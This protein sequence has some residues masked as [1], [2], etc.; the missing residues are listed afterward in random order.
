MLPFFGLGDGGRDP[1]PLRLALPCLALPACWCG[2]V[3]HF[4]L[5]L[6][7]LE[8]SLQSFLK[9]L[10]HGWSVPLVVVAQRRLMTGSALAR[11]WSWMSQQ[12]RYPFQ[13]FVWEL[14]WSNCSHQSLHQWMPAQS[15][16]LWSKIS[17]IAAKWFVMMGP[18]RL[19]QIFLLNWRWPPTHRKKI[20]ALSRSVVQS[21]QIRCAG[22]KGMLL[23]SKHLQGTRKVEVPRSMLKFG[24]SF[25]GEHLHV[26]NFSRIRPTFLGSH[27]ALLLEAC[28]CD[29]SILIQEHV[30]YLKK[31]G[32]YNVSREDAFDQLRFAQRAADDADGEKEA[33][34]TGGMRYLGTFL[35][36]LQAGF[37]PQQHPLLEQV[38]RQKAK[39]LLAA[40]RSVH[41]RDVWSARGHPEPGK[42]EELQLHDNEIFLMVPCDGEERSG[43]MFFVFRILYYTI[44]A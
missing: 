31:V 14:V 22:L 42:R 4:S 38:L 18:V 6:P 35:R 34:F 19:I 9:G 13:Y 3:V 43:F 20:L 41:I 33:K 29:T 24:E 28:G 8:V 37:S 30:A 39:A 15:T 27:L 23:G 2:N 1:A 7:S 12:K 11:L 5:P 21:A 26:L 36:M 17:K 25:E 32:N 40:Q 16:S 10:Q 44:H